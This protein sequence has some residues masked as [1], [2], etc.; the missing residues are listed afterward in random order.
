[1]SYKNL[2][3]FSGSEHTMRA[4]VTGANSGIGLAFAKNLLD[5][6]VLPSL[7]VHPMWTNDVK[8]GHEVHAVD[9][10]SGAMDELGCATYQCDLTSAKSIASLAE[11]FRGRPLDILLNIA[12]ICDL[13]ST[14]CWIEPSY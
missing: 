1:M 9:I 8:Q 12:G 7:V 3:K 5:E 10:V 2:S 11:A 14:A 4:L 6:V 13:R